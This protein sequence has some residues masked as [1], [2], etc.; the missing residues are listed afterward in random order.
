MNWHE[1][2]SLSH[3]G[4]DIGAKTMTY[5]ILNH[6]SSPDLNFEVGQSKMCLQNHGV[7][8]VLSLLLPRGLAWDNATVINT[9]AKWNYDLAVNGYGVVMFLHCNGWKRY[10]SQTDCRTFFNNATLTYANRYSLRE[11]THPS[12]LFIQ[13]YQSIS[14]LCSG[15]QYSY[16]L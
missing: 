3:Q 6:L 11:W 9:I 7:I 14:E 15:S 5:K 10:S 12:R 16:C 2:V 13:R 1:I 8:T 4:N